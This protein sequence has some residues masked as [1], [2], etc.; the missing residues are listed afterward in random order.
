M[1]KFFYWSPCLDKVG[2]YK[3]VKNSALAITIA[4]VL[5]DNTVFAVPASIY[6]LSMYFTGG[7]IVFF[8]IKNIKN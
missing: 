8:S 7:L 3:A 5:L 6:T 2:T 1:K 4:I